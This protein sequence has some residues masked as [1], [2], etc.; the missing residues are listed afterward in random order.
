MLGGSPAPVSVVPTAA[1]ED[2]G[3]GGAQASSPFWSNTSITS[4]RAIETPASASRLAWWALIRSSRSLGI[5]ST[6]LRRATPLGG[7]PRTATDIS[8]S[9]RRYFLISN[10]IWMGIY[11]YLQILYGTT[12]RVC[13]GGDEEVWF[14]E[15][16]LSELMVGWKVCTLAAILAYRDRQSP[17][18][19]PQ[20]R[21]TLAQTTHRCGGPCL[22]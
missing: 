2:S 8:P 10:S 3:A 15:D 7:L 1:T 16:R 22:P 4:C 14:R 17:S 5:R 20:H 6:T 11:R 19:Q 21:A 12:S 18:V 9:I 13:Q